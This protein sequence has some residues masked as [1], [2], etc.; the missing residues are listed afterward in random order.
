MAHDHVSASFKHRRSLVL[1]LVMTAAFM[2]VEAAAGFLTD[3]LVLIADAG[4]M[5]TD[6]AGISLALV[7]VWFAQR[8]AT[9]RMTYGYYRAE[10][11][12]ALLNA[13]LLLGVSAYIFYEAFQRFSDPPEVP[14]IPLIVV[15]SGGL[16][17][18]LIG[19]RMLSAG[20]QES[21]NVRG[22]FLEVWKDVLGSVAAIAAGLIILLTGWYYADPILAAA[23]GLLILPRTWELLKGALDVLFEGTPSHVDMREVRDAILSVPGVEAVHDLHV[24]TVTSGFVALSGHVLVRNDSDRDE[25]LVR[26]RA[27]LAGRFSIEHVTVQVE[28]DALE[29]RLDQPCLPEVCYEPPLAVGAGTQP[30]GV[31]ESDRE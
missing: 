19:A 28:N 20:A 31:P 7:A 14:S 13:M 15:A 6:V 12:A 10:I 8:P 23:V 24:W 25:I 9:D 18:N 16:L 17:V 1:V 4:H 2:V 5:L 26:M 30:K 11:L 29:S 27:E 3:S 21:M 22:A